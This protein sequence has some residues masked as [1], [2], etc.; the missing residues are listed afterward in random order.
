M[1]IIDSN[2]MR[3]TNLIIPYIFQ[4]I[5]LAPRLSLWSMFKYVASYVYHLSMS[6]LNGGEKEQ[7]KI[8]LGHKD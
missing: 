4:I 8:F 3:R 7:K 5:H 1:I 2:D 6:R